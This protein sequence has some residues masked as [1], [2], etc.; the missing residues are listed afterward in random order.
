MDESR[1]IVFLLVRHAG[2]ARRLCL[3]STLC[4]FS[5]SVKQGTPVQDVMLGFLESDEY[6][7][8]HSRESRNDPCRIG[9]S[10]VRD[11]VPSDGD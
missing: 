4:P 8:K 7:A 2:Q 3:P 9:V 10:L 6:R 5:P 11:E 1:V